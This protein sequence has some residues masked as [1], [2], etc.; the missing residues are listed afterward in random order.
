MCGINALFDPEATVANAR[1][2]LE[3]MNQAFRYRGPDG[4]GYFVDAPAALAM[5]RLAIIDLEGGQQPLFN[6]DGTVAV[7]CNGEIYNHVEL[8]SALEAR[9]HRFATSSDCETLVH[10]YEDFDV[11]LFEHLRGMFA[12]ALW[13]VRR[14]RLLAAR[15][16]L[17]IKPLYFARKGRFL[18]LSSELKALVAT[19]AAT[20]SVDHEKVLE[21]LRFTYPVDLRQTIASDVQRVLPGHYVLADATGVQEERYWSDE[22][23]EQVESVTPEEV[24]S[25]VARAVELHLRSDVPVAVLL[26]GGIDSALVASYAS[27]SSQ[28]LVGI[29]AGYRGLHDCDERVDAR[30]SAGQIGLPLLEVELDE[31]DFADTVVDIARCCD[32]P[33]LDIASIAQW[34]L[35]GQCRHLGYKVVLSGIGGDELFFG[36]PIWNETGALLSSD[37]AT[38]DD[39]SLPE[40]VRRLASMRTRTWLDPSKVLPGGITSTHTRLL[41]RLGQSG[42][43]GDK[44]V[45]ELMGRS[46]TS[47]ESIYN[48]IRRAYLTQNGL[49]LADKLGMGRSVEVR[50]PLADHALFEIARRLPFADRFSL[51]ESKPFLRRIMRGRVPEAI[52]QAIKRGFTPPTSF[53]G[54]VVEHHMELVLEDANIRALFPVDA[55]RAAYLDATRA[56]WSMAGERRTLYARVARRTPAA[57]WSWFLFELVMAVLSWQSWA[58]Q[59]TGVGS[60][61]S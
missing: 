24:E 43:R 61:G 53:V 45:S 25:E 36:Y 32:E 44:L 5:R 3:A 30:R 12:F 11:R 2:R 35:Y 47:P 54:A 17:G 28:R 22:A 18:A 57:A 38:L 19:G 42:H 33:A 27:R 23:T 34:A 9:G 1:A 13:D 21:S 56:K 46:A 60:T 37:F 31:R 48:F 50:V 40:R 10:L 4:E 39:R 15:D 29:S 20:S 58:G 51:K 16:R 49:Q 55:L 8:R 14:R 26:S 6:E 7:V 52:R 41:A 59:P